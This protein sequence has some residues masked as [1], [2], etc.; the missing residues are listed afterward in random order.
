MFAAHDL[1]DSA[2]G[3]PIRIRKGQFVDGHGRTLSL[4]G[5]NVSGASKLPSRPDGLT[6]LTEGFYEHRTVTFVN[7]PFT[8]LEAPLHFRRLQAWGLPVIR[9]LVTWESLA[10]RGPNPTTDLDLEY[11][12]YLRDLIEMMPKYG[13]KCFIC[14]H[15]DVW[16]RF[17]GGSKFTGI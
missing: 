11:I 17:S 10:H 6:H 13:I 3:G 5:M 1:S 2:L 15:Q 7:R 8:L 12:S 14:A 16:S 4:R 9:L